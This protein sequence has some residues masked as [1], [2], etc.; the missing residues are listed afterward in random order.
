MG[1][2]TDR[3]VLD[4]TLSRSHP[5]VKQENACKASLYMRL[6]NSKI[7]I[8]MTLFYVRAMRRRRIFVL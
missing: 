7:N 4:W 5:E 1:L 3:L 6:V 8:N 2:C